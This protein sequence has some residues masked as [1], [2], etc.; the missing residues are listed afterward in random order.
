MDRV[1]LY[2]QQLIKAII[3]PQIYDFLNTILISNRWIL[4]KGTVV[5]WY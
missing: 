5:K 1:Q 4:R 3:Q 2:Q